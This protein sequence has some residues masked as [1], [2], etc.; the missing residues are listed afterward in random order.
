MKNI[1]IFCRVVDNFGDIGVCWRLAQSLSQKSA[2][3]IHLWVDDLHSFHKL[4]AGLNPLLAQQ[5]VQNI[6]VCHWTDQADFSAALDAAVIIEAF[7]CDLPASLQSRMA[8]SFRQHRTQAAWINLE[9]L[10]AEA[11]VDSCHAMV[12]TQAQTGLRKYFYFPGFSAKTGGL[13]FEPA[14]IQALQ[15]FQQDTLAQHNFLA[16]LGVPVR[17][18]A[19]RVSLFC[20]PDAPVLA[21]LQ[22]LQGSARP[23]QIFVAQGVASRQLQD[24]TGV[25]LQ[26]GMRWQAGELS[27]ECLPFIDQADYD[28]LLACCELNLVRGEDSFVRAQL[29][30]LPMLW[31]IYPQEEQAHEVKLRAFLNVYLAEARE[32]KAAQALERLFCAWNKLQKLDLGDL[33]YLLDHPETRAI[34]QVWQRKIL[35]NGDL[36]SRLLQFIEEI[37]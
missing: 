34:A 29:L 33:D 24:F 17:G 20:Y 18:G 37:G 27:I 35:Q 7:A 12:S 31:H 5:T 9:Y 2:L 11:W 26:A 36:A 15:Q 32:T 19:K 23:L 28:Y 25:E 3:P 22:H 30:G 14:H 4:C 1:S 16:R 13:L 6:E 21:W 8:D 10:S